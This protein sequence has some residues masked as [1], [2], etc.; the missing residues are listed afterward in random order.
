MRELKPKDLVLHFY[1]N[2]WPDGIQETRISGRS[3]VERS[4]GEIFLEPPNAGR[5]G[6]MGSYY[7]IDLRDYKSFPAPLPLNTLVKKYRDEL[8][9]DLKENKPTHYPFYAVN[10]SLRTVQGGY[11]TKCTS[12]LYTT[13]RKALDLQASMDVFQTKERGFDIHDDYLEAKKRMHESFLFLRNAVLAR[14]VKEKYGYVCQG[15]GFD[16]EKEY[17]EIG[18]NYIEC[19]HL[20]PLSERAADEW[21][22]GT[23]SHES[24]V[25]VL[26]SNCH[27]MVHRRQPPLSLDE[28]KSIIT[29]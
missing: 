1:N 3:F 11:I 7:R 6:N 13:I 29:S 22:H 12:T 15:C 14:R 28:L 5:W 20:V 4:I 23:I 25:T 10:G 27:S 8:T 16:F 17:G 9:S 24:D 26:C 21:Q 2:R 18:R 19:H